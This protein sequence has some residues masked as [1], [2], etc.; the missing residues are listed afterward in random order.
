M[1]VLTFRQPS[2][3]FADQIRAYRAESM[4]DGPSINGASSLQDHEDPADWIAACAAAAD[5]A[6]VDPDWVISHQWLCVDE[7]SQIVG[8]T[9]IRPDLSLPYAAEYAGHIGYSIRPSQRGKGYG[10][11]QLRLALEACRGYGLALALL[12]CDQANEASRRTIMACGGVFERAM[13]KRDEDE[14]TVIAMERYW[15]TL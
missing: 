10:T 2:T 4:L 8:M 1:T 6:T 11:Q 13:E 5:P 3:E 9:A 15:I 12:T 7:A 14:G